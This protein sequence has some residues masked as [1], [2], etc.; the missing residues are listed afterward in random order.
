MA[1][2]SEWSNLFRLREAVLSVVSTP[3]ELVADVLTRSSAKADE[4]VL[5]VLLEWP[6][7]HPSWAPVLM[8]AFA[9]GKLRVDL[10]GDVWVKGRL[11]L[12]SELAD[13]AR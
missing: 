2:D 12:S 8:R 3:F 11:I 13:K 1:A 10:D 4:K 5:R 9:D 7:L 6:L